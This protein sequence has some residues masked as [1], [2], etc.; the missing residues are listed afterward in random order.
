MW[1]VVWLS[2][3]YNRI[4]FRTVNVRDLYLVTSYQHFLEFAKHWNLPKVCVKMFHMEKSS[5]H[6][7]I[8]FRVRKI[9]DGNVYT[10]NCWDRDRWAWRRK[11]RCLIYTALLRLVH[12]YSHLTVCFAIF[13]NLE[14]YD[15]QIRIRGSRTHPSFSS[16]LTVAAQL[17]VKVRIA[18]RNSTINT[19]SVILE[20]RFIISQVQYIISCLASNFCSV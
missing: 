17:T 3:E 15:C 13:L 9:E 16:C 6:L 11:H 8:K 18:V 7:R 19:S 2:S 1:K 20:H 12:P 10:I 4:G 14:M 5:T